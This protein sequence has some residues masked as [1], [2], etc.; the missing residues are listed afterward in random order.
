MSYVTS[1]N[2]YVDSVD[3]T[4]TQSAQSASANGAGVE[5]GRNRSCTATLV[6]TAC[7][8]SDTLDVKMQGSMDG[9]TWFDLGVAFTQITDATSFPSTQRKTFVGARYVRPV[10]TVAGSSVSISS[11][12]TLEAV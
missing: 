12:V 1:K 8:A 6:A 10:F 11:S 2:K 5:L 9:S 4:W 7:S 3:Y